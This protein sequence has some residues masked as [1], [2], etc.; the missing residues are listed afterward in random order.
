MT[1]D[2]VNKSTQQYAD[3]KTRLVF[4]DMDRTILDVGP[5]HRQNF[6]FVLQKMFG[7][8]ELPPAETSGYPYMEVVRIYARAAGIGDGILDSQQTELETQLVEN[9]LAILPDEL[10]KYVFPGTVQLLEKLNVEKIPIGLT[11]GSLRAIAVP[12]LK[13]SGLLKYFPVTSF[14][15]HVSTREQIVEQG[16]E[17]AT[18][19]YGM[20]KEDFQLVTIGD[21]PEDIR[22]GKAFGAITI[23]VANGVYSTKQLSAHGPDYVFRDLR[24]TQAIFDKITTK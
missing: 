24:D 4:F 3:L 21:A 16:L 10:T 19:V 22:A 12:L 7:V 15:D 17:K 23:S 1:I 18:W 6:L 2:L 14:G 13:R 20:S 5:Y 9:M 11:T 8:M